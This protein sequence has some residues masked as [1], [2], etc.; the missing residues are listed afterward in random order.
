MTKSQF[1]FN[2]KPE[3]RNMK[4]LPYLVL[5]LLLTVGGGGGAQ[6]STPPPSGPSQP[7]FNLTGMWEVWAQSNAVP[8]TGAID[9][10]LTRQ[11]CP[12]HPPHFGHRRLLHFTSVFQGH[13]HATHR[14]FGVNAAS[15]NR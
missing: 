15:T 3:R 12:H 1:Q 10:N 2:S 13:N 4:H 11:Y 6:S 14:H 7:A 5:A 8:V 9:G